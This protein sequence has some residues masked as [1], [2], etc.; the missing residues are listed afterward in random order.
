MAADAHVV[1]HRQVAEQRE[2][3]E[4]AADADVGDAVRRPAQDA[5]ALE[6]DVAGARRVEPAEAV[7]QR[8]LAGAVRADQAEDLAL[9]HV[10]RDVVER[11]DA[12]ERAR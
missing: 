10:E 7:E 5:A 1:E 12:A 8:R 11:D 2:V 9:P 6:Q 4:G 3:L